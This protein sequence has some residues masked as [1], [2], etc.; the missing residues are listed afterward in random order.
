MHIESLDGIALSI[1]A[2]QSM[3]PRHAHQ[4]C[5]SEKF[6]TSYSDPPCTLE[7]SPLL[8]VSPSDPTKAEDGKTE[9]SRGSMLMPR[10]P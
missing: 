3:H 5:A 9:P 1:A 2:E 7:A 8:M 10:E 4:Q 6:E